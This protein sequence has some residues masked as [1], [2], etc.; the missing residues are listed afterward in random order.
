MPE[1]AR[2]HH[3][4]SWLL[5]C[6]VLLFAP[7]CATVQFDE[8]LV[9]PLQR[10]QLLDLDSGALQTVTQLPTRHQLDPRHLR[11]FRL[12]LPFEL[13]DPAAA[14]LWAAYFLTL[15]DG[16]QVQLNGATI[17]D[18]PSS[19]RERAV[20]NI[21]PVMFV[22]A[23]ELLRPGRN[24]LTLQWATHD[25]MQ[26]LA[27][28]FIGPAPVVRAHYE[29][30][31]FW[32]NT[33][34]QVGFDFALVSA[35]LLLGIYAMQPRRPYLLMGLT[36][37]GWAVVCVAYF[38][39]PMPPALYPGWH[40]L[41]ISGIA[42]TACCTWLFLH[43]ETT[44]RAASA[45]G[46][47][48]I[49]WALLG[50]LGYLVDFVWRD[51]IYNAAFETS[52]AAALLLLGLVP[53]WR[54]LRALAQRWD[55][56]RAVFLLAALTAG[57]AGLAD[58]A[59]AGTGSG[60]FGAVG[61][62]TPAV[63]PI[64]FAAIVLVLVRDFARFL[65]QQRQ[66]QELLARRLSAQQQELQTLHARERQ[67]E[68]AHVALQERQ[69]IMQDMHDGL[70]SQ[71]VSSLALS[72][73]HALSP[74]QTTALLRDCIDDLRLAIDSLG[75]DGESF[76]LMAGNLRFRMAP[77]LRAAGIA[78]QWD[79][80]G[81]ADTPQ[82]DPAQALALLRMLQEC[83]VNALKHAQASAISV[84][85]Q[86]TDQGLLMRV[87][88][89]GLGFDAAQVRHGKGLHGLEKRAQ[90]LGARLDIASGAGTTVEL[91]LPL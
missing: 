12:V 31:Q 50:P 39:P 29:R 36:S 91:R 66:Q 2:P 64:W 74:E 85:L 15:N 41:R 40:L 10:G 79:A 90:A 63:S 43:H 45:F 81:L 8:R 24:E 55:W 59:M 20:L 60:V 7:A 37:L 26:H 46:W 83:L 4:T 35:A 82:P 69:R 32:Q 14:P 56:R 23:P 78:L 86:T 28:A 19:T 87:H 1:R 49:G 48:C 67:R 5:V 62:S 70:G 65:S 57:V 21:R 6:L 51:A 27:P 22:I 9:V 77:R 89:N 11:R 71:L 73:R 72:E 3:W 33:M 54:L 25:S 13:H 80:S 88:D 76:A 53:I 18:I 75:A 44:G 84:T 58:V 34:A 68:R 30:R 42:T 47:L 38:V 61:Y 52:W 16:G 17:G